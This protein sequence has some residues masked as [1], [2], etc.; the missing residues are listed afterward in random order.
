MSQIGEPVQPGEVDK[1]EEPCPF[2][3]KEVKPPKVDNDL[4]GVGTKL[5]SKM[6][7]ASG[8]LLY[9]PIAKGFT[10]SKILNPKEVPNHPFNKKNTNKPV[11]IEVTDGTK[12]HEH[13]YPVTCAAHHLI[14]AQESLKESPLLTFMCKKDDTEK[15]KGMD[16]SDGVVWSDLGYDVN[17]SQNGMFLPGSYAVGGG[18]G[19]MKVWT[20]AGG[21]SEEEDG[22]W[23]ENDDEDEDKPEEDE[24]E[25]AP[26]SNLL[27]GKLNIISDRNRKWQYVRQ[28]VEKCPGQ[29]HDRHVD[30]STKVVQGILKKMFE[31]YLDLMTKMIWEEKCPDC[32]K[33]R[34]DIEKYGLPTPYGLA[35]R[36]N[37]VSDRLMTYL[38]GT[39]WRINVYT[40]KWG[41]AFMKWTLRQEARR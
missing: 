26:D 39:T 27:T 7:S 12:K 24:P 20:G 30:Y 8:T 11:K 16:F 23:A 29:F 41:K 1:D 2:D 5:A 33:R 9:E 31:N 17:G 40:S 22:A 36:L 35:V 14:P 25:A 28:A 34:E 4:I 13:Y 38:N 21:G 3:H 37:K 6:K 18:R 15:L 10:I 19:G 32:K